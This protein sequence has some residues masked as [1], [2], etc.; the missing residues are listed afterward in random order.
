MLQ[1]LG[2]DIKTEAVKKMIVIEGGLGDEKI[3]SRLTFDRDL[4]DEDIAYIAEYS[5][6]EKSLD[7]ALKLKDIEYTRDEVID[8]QKESNHTKIN[9]KD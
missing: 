3:K 7:K 6:I 9:F 4:V 2:A 5:V 1:V 8:I